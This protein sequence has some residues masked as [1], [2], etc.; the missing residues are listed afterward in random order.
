MNDIYYI[1]IKEWHTTKNIL[2]QLSWKK[3]DFLKRCKCV[4]SK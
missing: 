3:L 1:P 4:V 2:G